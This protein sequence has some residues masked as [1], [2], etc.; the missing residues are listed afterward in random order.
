MKGSI[1]PPK[2]VKRKDIGCKNQLFAA[3]VVGLALLGQLQF[4]SRLS[5]GWRTDA[6]RLELQ[7]LRDVE[8]KMYKLESEIQFL[9]EIGKLQGVDLSAYRNTQDKLATLSYLHGQPHTSDNLS[10]PVTVSSRLLQPLGSV[11]HNSTTLQDNS[12]PPVYGETTSWL[13][14]ETSFGWNNVIYDMLPRYAITAGAAYTRW[15]DSRYREKGG[16]YWNTTR[17]TEGSEKIK[18]IWIWGERNSCTSVITKIIQKNF[19]LNCGEHSAKTE[20]SKNTGFNEVECV[21][22]GLPWKHD[23]ARRAGI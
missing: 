11:A 6:H 21:I 16:R 2:H 10:N 17:K 1:L 7:R 4:C 18:R 12:T 14:T 15:M 8:G 5:D 22:G 9:I 20:S 3:G 23:F 19:N 13:V